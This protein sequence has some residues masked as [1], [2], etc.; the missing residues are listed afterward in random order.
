MRTTSKNLKK[1][2]AMDLMKRVKRQQLLLR[3]RRKNLAN[4]YY[5]TNLP[6]NKHFRHQKCLF[7]GRFVLLYRATQI[8]LNLVFKMPGIKAFLRGPT[9]LKK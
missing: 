2:S 5:K 4:V 6:L 9:R 1:T 7:R 3:I 8:P